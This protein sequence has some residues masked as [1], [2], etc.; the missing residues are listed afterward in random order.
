M[1]LTEAYV[2]Y[3]LYLVYLEAMQ[4]E[5]VLYS[6][7]LQCIWSW[8]WCLDNY[9]KSKV[10]AFIFGPV[11]LEESY[12]RFYPCIIHNHSFICLNILKRLIFFHF[13]GGNIHVI[14]NTLQETLNGH[15]DTLEVLYS[16]EI[17][18]YIY[19]LPIL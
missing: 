16:V 2:L 8:Y 11:T 13:I 17:F 1:P 15:R 5:G 19:E 14:Q 9:V 18:G 6:I 12:I 4:N 3:A 10:L 7:L